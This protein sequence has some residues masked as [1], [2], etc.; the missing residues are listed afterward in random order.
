MSRR[1]DLVGTVRPMSSKA[2]QAPLA[3]AVVVVV[4]V[5][6]GRNNHGESNALAG[7]VRTAA[8][9]LIALAVAWTIVGSVAALRARP[10]AL[11]PPG[12]VVWI[13][14]AIG[15]LVL[16]RLVF[17]RGTATPFVIV[18]MSVLAAGM[19]GWRAV[20]WLVERRSTAANRSETA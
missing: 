13:G 3:D 1:S 6:L 14:T 5:M 15:G 9:F 4:F 19:F 16:R 20:V 2:W 7:V 11:W 12:M 18:A 10:S 8:P 17:D